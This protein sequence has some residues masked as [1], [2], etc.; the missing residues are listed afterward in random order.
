MSVDGSLKLGGAAMKRIRKGVLIQ[1][2]LELGEWPRL[3]H[4]VMEKNFLQLI[5]T[6]F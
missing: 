2:S 3:H 5:A 1:G 6:D 4:G